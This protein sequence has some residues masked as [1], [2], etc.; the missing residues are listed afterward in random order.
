MF[1]HAG[2]NVKRILGAGTPGP[3]VD[4]AAVVE[5]HRDARRTLPADAYVEGRSQQV[6][7]GVARIR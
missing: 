6:T 5:R 7:S 1:R 4:G 3:C 2:W